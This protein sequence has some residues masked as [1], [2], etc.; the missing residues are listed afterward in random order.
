MFRGTIPRTIYPIIHEHVRSWGIKDLYEPCSGNLTIMGLLQDIPGL[1]QHGNDVTLYSCVLGK[2]YANDPIPIQPKE[3]FATKYPWMAASMGN[4]TDQLAT[5]LLVSRMMYGGVLKSNT[6]ATRLMKAWELQWP[7]KHAETVRRIKEQEWR[8][9]SFHAGDAFE[10]IDE[11]PENA[12]VISYPPFVGAAKAFDR[13]LGDLEDYF[14]WDPPDWTPLEG[15]AAEIF[16][17]KLT[18]RDHWMFGSNRTWEQFRP[19]LR[20]QAQS[21]NRGTK[22]YVYSSQGKSRVIIP[23]QQI[24]PYMVPRMTPGKRIGETMTLEPISYKHFQALRSQYMNINIRPGSATM[25]VAV[26]VDG[27]LVGVYAFN[28]PDTKKGKVRRG[29]VEEPHVYMLSDFPVA[30]SDYPRLSK[31]ILYAALSKESQ[32]L[33]ERMTRSHVRGVTTTAFTNK[34]VSMKYR[35]IF[36][37][38]SRKENEVAQGK[39]WYAADIDPSNTYY[40]QKFDLNYAA[41][42]GKWTLQEGLAMWKEKHGQVVPGGGHKDTGG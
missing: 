32:K 7:E 20:C 29:V 28:P 3:E 18:Q 42:I 30:P 25:P 2:Y 34:P 17:E 26:L 8:I 23:R 11:L 13:E 14:T 36:K 16:F 19:N 38:Y 5:M 6:Y 27:T 9:A 24:E 39:T 22:V 21:T 35:G 41:N 1:R 12:A 37:L 40:K 31:L 4:V 10:W 15:D 33:A